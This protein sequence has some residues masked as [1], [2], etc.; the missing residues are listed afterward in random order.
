[1]KLHFT[2]VE[3]NAADQL[4]IEIVKQ[5]VPEIDASMF[6]RTNIDTPLVKMMYSDEG[7][8]I[9][10]DPSITIAVVDMYRTIFTMGMAAFNA[11]KPYL[12][13]LQQQQAKIAYM[14]GGAM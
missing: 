4:T 3:Q 6:I 8:T 2:A 5:F 11:A 14:C 7:T 1:M 10:V 12:P 9:E 13:E